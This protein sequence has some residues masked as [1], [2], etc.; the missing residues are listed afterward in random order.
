MQRYK[1]IYVDIPT[2][3][4]VG[5]PEGACANVRTF[6]N[7]TRQEVLNWIRENLV[8]CDDEGRISIMTLGEPMRA[9]QMP[10]KQLVD[11]CAKICEYAQSHSADEEAWGPRDGLYSAMEH[12]SFVV[13][14]FLSQ[15][16]P[17][18]CGGVDWD[19][20]QNHLVGPVLD[21]DRWRRIIDSIVDDLYE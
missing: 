4:M 3:S 14:C 2:T 7:A 11:V 17:R 18:G 6:C 1:E 20:V 21:L 8:P 12:T 13:A 15:N 10:R 19:I 5:K 16:T 9:P